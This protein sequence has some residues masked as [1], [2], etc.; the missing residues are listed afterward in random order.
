MGILR[1][2]IEVAVL[3]VLHTG[4]DLSLGR[5]I[6]FE[7]VRNDDARYIREPFEEFAEKLLGGFSVP[8]TLHQNIKHVAIL[9]HRPPE[10]MPLTTN[11][12]ENFVQVPLVTRSGAPT[13]QLI[14]TGL[15]KLQ[16]PFADCFV[17]HDD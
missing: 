17:G 7:F 1:T 4:E 11:G 2:V 13:T 3:A 8:L 14:C 5:S 12:E 9:I 6:T 16:T 15:S 10:I